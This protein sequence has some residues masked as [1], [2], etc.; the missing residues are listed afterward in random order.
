MFLLLPLLFFLLLAPPPCPAANL[1]H[2]QEYKMI[3]QKMAEQQRK[4][5]EAQERESS[6]L[7][8]I[9]DVSMRLVRIETE[10]AMYRKKLRRAEAEIRSV[11]AEI[12][13]TRG[14][15]QKQKDWLKRKL[16]SMNRFGYSSDMLVLLMSAG[17]ISQMMRTWKYLERI[18][19]YEHKVLGDYRE[20]LRSYTERY[21]RLKAL[22]T[23]LKA[24]E[25][26]VRAKENELAGQKETKETIL[27]S[28]R[29]EKKSRREMLAEL[30][31]ASRRLRDLIERSSRTDTYSGTGMAFTR[32]KGKLPWPA[33]GRI[34]IPYGTQ[35]DPQFNTPVFRTGVHIETA[36]DSE[37][38]AVHEGKVIY[39]EWFKGFGQLVIVNHGGGYHTLYGNLSEIFSHVGDIIQE[40][41]VIGKVGTS[42]ILNAPGLYF[43]IR[44]KS[45]P[46]DPAQWLKHRRG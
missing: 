38:R 32:L 26:H 43:E 16:R 14:I 28:V 37:A 10:L 36:P 45:K 12:N 11:T 18:A 46:L 29:K 41:Q 2:E 6:I 8:E 44:Y 7:G 35:R 19:L 33:I 23:Q 15:L 25:E 20:N 30:R 9:Q 4:I 42:G 21:E 17:D 22:K 31:E 5:R 34:A 39:A 27:S 13:K 1:S 3:Q 40:N 24:D